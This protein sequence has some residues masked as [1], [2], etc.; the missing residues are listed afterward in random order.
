[1]L[2]QGLLVTLTG[3]GRSGWQ[4]S[5]TDQMILKWGPA[6]LGLSQTWFLNVSDS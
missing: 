6:A 3:S 1:M 5:L 2:R 4:I